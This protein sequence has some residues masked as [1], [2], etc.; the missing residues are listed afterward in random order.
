[1]VAMTET[2][3]YEFTWLAILWVPDALRKLFMLNAE[4]VKL[5]L[6]EVS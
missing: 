5:V 3:P 1:M 2:I 4:A 6:R